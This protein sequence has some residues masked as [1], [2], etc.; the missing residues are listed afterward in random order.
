MSTIILCGFDPLAGEKVNPS[1][2]V[3][4]RLDGRSIGGLRIEAVRLPVDCAR[5][6]RRITEAIRASRPDAVLGLGQAGGRPVVSLE[7][8]AINL[9]AVRSGNGPES[10]ALA[11]PVVSGGPD[12]YFT[13]LPLDGILRGL[14]RRKIPAELSL[15]AGA[16]ACN[17]V[18]YAALHALRNRPAV[19]AGFI[20][21]PYDPSQAAR[22]RNAPSM[23]PALMEQAVAL[24]V[25][26]IAQRS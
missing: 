5:A 1:W 9:I 19:A 13:R 4:R 3:A 15:S 16:Y 11:R 21:L 18:M 12:A 14:K 24:A 20:H 26:V 2:E 17:A 25:G 6:A 10:V 22:K 7:W 8:V 23:S